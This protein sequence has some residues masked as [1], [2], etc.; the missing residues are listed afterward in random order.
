MQVVFCGVRG[1]TA[2]PGAEFARYGGHTSCVSLARDGIPPTLVLDAGTGLRRLSAR[3]APSSFRGTILLGHLHWDHT[4]G[5]PFFAAGDRPDA[6]VTLMIPAQGDTEATLQRVMSP[7]HFPITPRQLRGDWRFAG[8][9]EGD[10]DIEGFAVTALEIP[11]KGG[12]TFGYRVSDGTATT[13]YLSDHWPLAFGDGP[14]GLGE[15]HPA[16]RR[17]AEG[18]DLL[19]HDGQYTT[20]EFGPRRHFGHSAIDYAVGLAQVAGAR[21]LA[22]FHHDPNRTDE[23]LD[24]I[25]ATLTATVPVPVVIA[26]EGM[27]V[28]LPA[29]YPG[30][31]RAS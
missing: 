7:P 4:Q 6:R 1:S 10:H 30:A 21:R 20:D 18:V 29:A 9:E 14:A 16:A 28:D 13:A 23:E 12:R 31:Q 22:V 15:Y 25:A 5:L 3:L 27:V 2:A 19:V 17:L 26:A 8:L 11:H 24:A